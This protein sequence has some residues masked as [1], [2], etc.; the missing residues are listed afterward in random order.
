MNVIDLYVVEVLGNPVNHKFSLGEFWIVRV[1]ASGYGC[2]SE[3]EIYCKTL[4]EAEN[5]AIG[6]KFQG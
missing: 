6:Y 5:V 1:I 2:L 3:T 4:E